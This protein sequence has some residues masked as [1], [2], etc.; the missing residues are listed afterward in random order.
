MPIVEPTPSGIVRC[1]RCRAYVNPF[2]KFL[3]GGRRWRCNLC[4]LMN[5][6]PNDYFQPLGPNGMRLDIGYDAEGNMKRPELMSPITEF[7]APADYMVRPP[8]AATFLFVLDVSYY[9]VT[10]GILQIAANTLMQL[11]AQLPGEA[12]TKIGILTFDSKVHYYDLSGPRPHVQFSS[13]LSELFIPPGYQFLVNR[14]EHTKQIQ[15]LLQNLPNMFLGTKEVQSCL[16]AALNVA[17]HILS[18]IGGKLM[19]FTGLLPLQSQHKNQPANLLGPGRLALRFDTKMLGT[20]KEAA[21]LKPQGTWYKDFALDCSKHQI[22]VDMFLFDNKSFLDVVTLSQVSQLT[23]GQAYFYQDWNAYRDGEKFCRD[24]ERNLTRPMG[25]EAVMRVRCSH[26]VR[27][28]T[29]L[30]N[31]FL[32]SSDLLA[33]PGVDADKAFAVQFAITEKLMDVPYM[34]MQTALLYTTSFSERRI[35]VITAALPSTANVQDIYRYIDVEAVS[36]L[37]AKLAIEKELRT[38]PTTKLIDIVTA[39]TKDNR[40][41]AGQHQLPLPETLQSLPLF[42]LALS[43]TLAFRNTNDVHPD[44]RAGI[45][46]LLRILPTDLF[47]QFIYPT[48]YRVY[49]MDAE[50]GTLDENGAVV[51][52]PTLNLSS[53]KLSRASAFLLDNGQEIFVWLGR[54]VAAEIINALFGVQ[55][56]TQTDVNQVRCQMP[57]CA[58]SAAFRLLYTSPST[59]FRSLLQ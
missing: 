57:F 5:N 38:F 10:T 34:F 1:T 33:L 49:P 55:D 36:T 19:L 35:R 41:F 51:L 17:Q 2:V 31:V 20:P 29:H 54:E 37:I 15:E 52:P 42:T 40:T 23:G 46:N 12:R 4:N 18:P 27:V 43:K 59:T 16:G 44:A 11:I 32:R 7:V 6:V 58:L 53:E 50:C 3:E 47:I 56:L 13:D 30:G 21:L 39:Y 9:S 28:T 26:G 25:F 45:I 14:N 48:L 24:L 8:Q 22:S